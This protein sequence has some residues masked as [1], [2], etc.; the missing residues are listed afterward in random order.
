M[1]IAVS[2]GSFLTACSTND[3]KDNSAS[4]TT[5]LLKESS[6][7][8]MTQT[9]TDDHQTRSKFTAILIDDASENEDTQK[10]IRLSLSEVK[11]IE[12]PENILPMMQSNGVILNVTTEQFGEETSLATLKKGTEISF[13]LN[14]LP[15]MTMSIPP[16]IPGSAV[17]QVTI[18]EVR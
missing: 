3:K 11:A 10:T 14:G 6:G 9:S 1:I 5:E 12:D 17:D 15:I 18:N 7:Q 4:S 13:V 8:E 16:Q 2:S